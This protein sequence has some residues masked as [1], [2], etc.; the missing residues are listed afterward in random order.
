MTGIR[1]RLC[2]VSCAANLKP[3]KPE[4]KS[5]AAAQPAAGKSKK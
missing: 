4:P 5:T 2:T 1:Y 3:K